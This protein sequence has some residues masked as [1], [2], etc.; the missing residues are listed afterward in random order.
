MPVEII[1]YLCQFKCGTKAKSNTR[2]ILTH[3]AMCFKNPSVKACTTCKH[4]IYY[5]DSF[6][7]TD[8]YPMNTDHMVRGCNK[9]KHETFESLIKLSDYHSHPA[10]HKHPVRHCPLWES[11][12]ELQNP[13]S[14]SINADSNTKQIEP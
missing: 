1:K 12:I 11:R 13:E 4:E 8:P 3:E 9:V 7:V 5:K 6:A 14:A 2:Q 10:F